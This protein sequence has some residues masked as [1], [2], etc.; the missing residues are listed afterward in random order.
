MGKRFV[1]SFDCQKANGAR[2][3]QPSV[4]GCDHVTC[5]AL[6][7]KT[8]LDGLKTVPDDVMDEAGL[9]RQD[10]LDSFTVTD[11]L[12]GRKITKLRLTDSKNQIAP[13]EL[14]W[15]DHSDE[16]GYFVNV[17]VDF[18]AT[19][20]GDEIVET[21]LSTKENHENELVGSVPE[22]ILNRMR[23]SIN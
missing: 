20:A 13:F 23:P 2:L 9:S 11:N 10:I 3:I 12:I 15:S 8:V 5:H 21:I 4:K 22:S 14:V 19:L 7:I 16:N 6:G 17:H 1:T 18:D